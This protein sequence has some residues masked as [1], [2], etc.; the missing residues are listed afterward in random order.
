MPPVGATSTASTQ[1]ERP[2]LNLRAAEWWPGVW[3][4]VLFLGSCFWPAGLEVDA[5]GTSNELRKERREY[6]EVASQTL[7]PA[8]AL[9]LAESAGAAHHENHLRK[10]LAEVA[11]RS[12]AAAQAKEANEQQARE[13]TERQA[14]HIRAASNETRRKQE[15]KKRY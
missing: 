2:S 13:E 1:T 6:K 9:E 3:C 5:H 4:W 8:P 11:C 15:E 14:S 12:A 10:V 7:G